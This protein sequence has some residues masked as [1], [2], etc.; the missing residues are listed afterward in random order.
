MIAFTTHG[1]KLPMVMLG[2][3]TECG[4]T[5]WVF[6]ALKR[7]PR[8]NDWN[9]SSD[10]SLGRQGRWKGLRHETPESDAVPWRPFAERLKVVNGSSPKFAPL[11]VLVLL[12]GVP[13]C[14]PRKKAQD[15]R[16]FCFIAGVLIPSKAAVAQ[17]SLVHGAK[18]RK[19]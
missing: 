9:M 1:E 13:D 5:L 11:L 14:S 16:R 15:I 2:P 6:P 3:F 7:A 10:K 8:P 19:P 4:S 18:R 12:F 17:S